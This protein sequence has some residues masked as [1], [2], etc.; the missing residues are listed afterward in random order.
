MAFLWWPREW[1]RCDTVTD[2]V[3]GLLFEPG[4]VDALAGTMQRLWNDPELCRTLGAAGRHRSPR[5]STPPPTAPSD[6]A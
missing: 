2:G 5:N 3:T 4:N 1:A 6:A